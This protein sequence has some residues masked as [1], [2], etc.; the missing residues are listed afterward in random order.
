MTRDEIYN[1]VLFNQARINMLLDPSI[2]ILQPEIQKLEEEIAE[3][4]SMCEHEF[5]DGVCVICGKVE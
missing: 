2:F 5:E 1:K 4:Q 3:L